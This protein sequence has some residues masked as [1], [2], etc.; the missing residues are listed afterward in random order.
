MGLVLQSRLL[1]ALDNSVVASHDWIDIGDPTSSYDFTGLSAGNYTVQIRYTAGGKHVI[2]SVV[3]SDLNYELIEPASISISSAAVSTAISCNSLSDGTVSA[4]ASGGTGSLIYNLL[5]STTSGGTFNAATATDGDADG[6]Y[7][8]LGK[9]FYKVSVTDAEGCASVESLEVEV[10]EPASILISSAAV[11]TAISCNSLIDGTVSAV[12]SGG[13]GSLIYNLLVSTTSGGTFNAATA[14]DGDA[15]GSYT[16]L[17]KGFYKVSVTDAEGCAS[18]ESLEVEVVE[19]ASILISSAAVSTAI[20][21]NSLIDGTVSAVASG[22]TGS[23][24]YNLLISV[25]SGGLFNNATS[26]DGDLDGSYTGLEK[27]FYKVSV[28]D[29]EGCAS[30][31][32]SEVEVVEPTTLTIS[33]SADN[34]PICEGEEVVITATAGGGIGSYSYEFYRNNILVVSD[35]NFTISG[36][37]LTSGIFANN[38]KIQVKVTDDNNCEKTSLEINMIVNNKPNPGPITF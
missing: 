11:S 21:C 1:N 13:T 3:S 34:N 4:V 14:T 15:D 10:V 28:T 25:T 9:G 33:L 24:I 23:L 30:V 32:S 27:G 12:A 8:G 6:S 36:N 38:D 31:E 29:A 5:V 20:S 17:G 7:T 2:G 22:G 37:Q 26:T 35:A 18:V 19:P 16:G